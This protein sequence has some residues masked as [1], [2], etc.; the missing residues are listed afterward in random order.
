MP[1]PRR[2]PPIMGNLASRDNPQ[3]ARTLYGCAQFVLERRS[4]RANNSLEWE[5]ELRRNIQEP[6]SKSRAWSKSQCHIVLH[7]CAVV[8]VA[9]SEIFSIDVTLINGNKRSRWVVAH[10]ELFGLGNPFALVGTLRQKP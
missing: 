7:D 10:F 6:R 4:N 5:N 8:R 9:L 2:P 3:S 1:A